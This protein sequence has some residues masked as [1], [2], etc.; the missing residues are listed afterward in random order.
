VKILGIFPLFLRYTYIYG[1]AFVC[2]FVC[3]CA[4][5]CVSLVKCANFFFLPWV[6]MAKIIGGLIR[7]QG[8]LIK[9]H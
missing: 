1:K 6:Y 9:K 4:C 8:G 7:R 2:V 5:V 3:V